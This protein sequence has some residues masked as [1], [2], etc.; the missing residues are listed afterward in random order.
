ME[1]LRL[2]AA[3]PTLLP[4]DE[5]RR[6]EARIQNWVQIYQCQKVEV[7]TYACDYRK[8]DILTL[9]FHDIANNA[10]AITAM[11]ECSLLSDLI[12]SKYENKYFDL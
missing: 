7:V 6:F 8:L 9:Y 2:G 3:S 10:H 5:G 4:E 11:L 1:R 12:K